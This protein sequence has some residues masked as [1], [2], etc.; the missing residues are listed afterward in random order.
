MT[1]SRRGPLAQAMWGGTEPQSP[2][3]RHREAQSGEEALRGRRPG[4]RPG[5]LS[6]WVTQRPQGPCGPRGKGWSLNS[7]DHVDL[8][9][10]LVWKGH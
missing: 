4:A 5:R 8:F 3:L 1:C 10:A 6:S 9:Q 2:P 7:A